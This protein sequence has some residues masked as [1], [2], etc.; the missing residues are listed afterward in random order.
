MRCIAMLLVAACGRLGFEAAGGGITDDT[1]MLPPSDARSASGLVYANTPRE[2]YRIDPMTLAVTS[3]GAFN[4]PCAAEQMTDIAIDQ[5]GVVI[6]VTFD[7]VYRIDAETAACELLAPLPR[8][9]NGLSFV[10]SGDEDI[11]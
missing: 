10:P 1:T 7:N 2:L 4:G 9:F 8:D 11:L 6:G 3:V 5:S